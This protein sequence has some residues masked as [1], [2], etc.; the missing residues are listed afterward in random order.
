M[1]DALTPFEK[2]Y[3]LATGP[4]DVCAKAREIAGTETLAMALL[5]LA[6]E[7]TT[8]SVSPTDAS[9]I[10]KMPKSTAASRLDSIG[11][12]NPSTDFLSDTIVQS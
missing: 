9:N 7:G 8:L 1:E 5:K 2:L 11:L 12:K 3:L 10:L 6:Y 4:G